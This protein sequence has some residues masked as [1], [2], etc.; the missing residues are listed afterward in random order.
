MLLPLRVMSSDMP[1]EP[2]KVFKEL[3]SN[4]A[5]TKAHFVEYSAGV[6]KLLNFKVFHFH[7]FAAALCQLCVCLLPKLPCSAG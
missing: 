4:I 6:S 7:G 1:L 3:S 5:A 2:V